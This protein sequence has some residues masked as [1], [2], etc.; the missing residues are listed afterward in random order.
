MYS[1]TSQIVLDYR[2]KDPKNFVL[3]RRCLQN[4]MKTIQFFY[5]RCFPEIFSLI[6]RRGIKLES[7]FLL[8]FKLWK[9]KKK[10]A[11]TT[12]NKKPAESDQNLEKTLVVEDEKVSKE[13]NEKNLKRKALAEKNTGL[14]EAAK[15]R[16]KSAATKKELWDRLDTL[17]KKFMQAKEHKKNK[18]KKNL[19][20]W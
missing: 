1:K 9:D 6:D 14:K 4:H 20:S 8:T 13:L 3:L 2:N 7:E 18:S 10:F 16:R 15:K 11:E 19:I 5:S 17:N 12:D